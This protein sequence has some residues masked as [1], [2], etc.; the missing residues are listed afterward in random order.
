MMKCW[1]LVAVVGCGGSGMKM[2]GDG[3]AGGDGKSDG[4]ADASSPDAPP[5]RITISVLPDYLDDPIAN[6]PVV[7]SHPDGTLIGV[8]MTDAQG[9]ASHMATTATMVT[10]IKPTGNRGTVTLVDVEPGTAL[11]FGAL[12]M[13]RPTVATMHASWPSASTAPDSA[14]DVE[15]RCGGL[16]G[17]YEE[18][19]GSV[20][21]DARCAGSFD[22]TAVAFLN[23]HVASYMT[24]TNQTVHDGGTLAFT[25]TWTPAPVI[26]ANDTGL[27]NNTFLLGTLTQTYNQERF[28]DDEADTRGPSTTGSASLAYQL[29]PAPGSELHEELQVDFDAANEVIG[30][31]IASTDDV[32]FDMSA[33]IAPAITS[34]NYDA[35][36]QTVSWATA[37]GPAPVLSRTEISYRNASGS[38]PTWI[39]IAPGNVTSVT[40]PQLPDSLADERI[41]DNVQGRLMLFHFAKSYPE[42]VGDIDLWIARSNIYPAYVDFQG[43]PADVSRYTAVVNSF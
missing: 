18:L 25:G 34:V 6:L 38:Y 27:P 22:A 43:M 33:D 13:Q 37:A 28:F 39:I 8:E 29:P 21:L 32:S 10:L 5:D 3:A 26:L 19:S 7:F 20:A 40:P 31:R 12:W 23:F 16:G 9:H 15:T 42:V 30:R 35:P 36:S 1:V 11:R 41:V 14:Y 24:L 17:Y 2:P 4:P